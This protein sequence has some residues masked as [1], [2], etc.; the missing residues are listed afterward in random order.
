LVI[1]AMRKDVVGLKRHAQL[2]VRAAAR[3]GVDGR[4]A[5]A[6]QEHRLVRQCGSTVI[7][8]RRPVV[9]AQ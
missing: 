5:P 4:A 9:T 6:N 3:A 7:D 2:D 8:A 1:E